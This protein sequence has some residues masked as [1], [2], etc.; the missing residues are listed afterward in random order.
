MALAPL[1]YVTGPEEQPMVQTDGYDLADAAV[2][3]VIGRSFACW[4]GGYQI[5]IC[6]RL[7]ERGPS[8]TSIII[9]KR[10]LRLPL[11]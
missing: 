1:I 2:L 6:L 8:W 3:E 9:K 7:K 5:I 10:R 4:A 11:S